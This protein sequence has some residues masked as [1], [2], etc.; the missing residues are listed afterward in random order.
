MLSYSAAAGKQVVCAADYM[1]TERLLFESGREQMDD[2]EP[3]PQDWHERY[4]AGETDL[5]DQYNTNPA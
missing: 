4:A 2:D 1:G 3:V 5:I